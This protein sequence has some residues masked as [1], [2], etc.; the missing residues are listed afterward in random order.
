MTH[1]PLKFGLPPPEARLETS[2]RIEAA[3]MT[4]C[5][6]IFE[7]PYWS[8]VTGHL[9]VAVLPLQPGTNDKVTTDEL[10]RPALCYTSQFDRKSRT[11]GPL[12]SNP[13]LRVSAVFRGRVGNQPQRTQRN[14]EEN[15]SEKREVVSCYA[16]TRAEA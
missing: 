8:F 4:F 1:V 7:S 11:A 2:N 9:S 13:S 12:R 16:K 3:V 14:A 5:R 10:L 15:L 6:F